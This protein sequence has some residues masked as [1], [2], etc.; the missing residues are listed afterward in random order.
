[1]PLR[2]VLGGPR[3]VLLPPASGSALAYIGL[4][5]ELDPALSVL[6]FHAPG[7]GAVPPRTVPG[8]V[9]KLSTWVQRLP[10][11]G[12]V[13]LAG[14]SFGGIL[15]YEL[16][17]VLERLGRPPGGGGTA[18][19]LGSPARRGERPGARSARGAQV[20]GP[21]PRWAAPHGPA[22]AVPDGRRDN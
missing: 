9:R 11:D 10:D 5:R 12:P 7:L 4:S 1:M 17:V 18:R 21:S 6:G 15:A 19:Q 14:W 8:F 2:E 22:R 16:G 13:V 20:G 3:L